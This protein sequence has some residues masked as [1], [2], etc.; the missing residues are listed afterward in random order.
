MGQCC[1]PKSPE[2]IYEVWIPRGKGLNLR[3]DPRKLRVE[4]EGVR[5][6]LFMICKKCR[7]DSTEEIVRKFGSVDKKTGNYTRKGVYTDLFR[8]LPKRIGFA[9][10]II[11]HAKLQKSRA[12]ALVKF[13]EGVEA[14]REVV[15]EM[16]KIDSDAQIL[17]KHW[18]DLLSDLMRLL[19]PMKAINQLNG[20]LNGDG[21]TP[22]ASASVDNTTQKASTPGTN[23]D[24]VVLSVTSA[25]SK[26]REREQKNAWAVQASDQKL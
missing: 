22:S 18:T 16:K 21:I 14:Y 12:A 11:E 1:P 6:K 20:Q 24:S 19:D 13:H 7:K 5:D 8:S 2:P 9:E 15:V 23:L 4:Y 3:V 25:D 26:K 17:I 10:K